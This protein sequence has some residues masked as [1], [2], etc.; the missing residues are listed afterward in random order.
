MTDTPAFSIVIPVYNNGLELERCLH[1]IRETN[2]G[3]PVEIIVVDDCSPDE[4]ALIE[5]ASEKYRANYQRLPENSGPGI[6]RNQGA[7]LAKGDILIFIDAD[8]MAPQE[9][10]SRLTS[11]IRENKCL[12]TTSCYC[13]PVSQTWLTVFQNEDY[14]YRMPAT[15]CDSYFVNSCNFAI[16]RQIFLSLGGFPVERVG[17]DLRLGMILAQHGKP[18]R[19]LPDVGVFHDYHRSLRGFLKQRYSFA[20]HGSR[21]L[22]RH[23][24]SRASQVTRTVRSHNVARIALGMF[25][26]LLTTAG[27]ILTGVV[28]VLK[29]DLYLYFAL[30]TVVSLAA[31]TIVH[32]R[33]FLF[34]S[35][36]QGVTRTVSYLCL[37][38]LTDIVYLS[39][40]PR[41]ILAALFSSESPTVRERI[42]GLR[43]HC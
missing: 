14:S 27:L 6:A 11:P 23:D 10:I 13:G 9:W 12:A 1:S 32:G 16:E 39:A 15:E 22:F 3:C 2:S 38:F 20:F 17:E 8:C 18:A 25:S 24:S 37:Q 41:G 34:L 30:S 19:Y 26:A 36:R 43:S 35:R 33:F 21:I 40:A 31:W 7:L 4:G 42:A 29:H 28:I 5:S